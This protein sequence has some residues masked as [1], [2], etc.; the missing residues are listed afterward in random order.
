[1]Q[2]N[3]QREHTVS[4]VL[5]QRVRNIQT[6]IEVLVYNYS[7]LGK[8]RPTAHRSHITIPEPCEPTLVQTILHAHLDNPLTTPLTD[9][10]TLATTKQPL[11]CEYDRLTLYA[12]TNI[13]RGIIIGRALFCRVYKI[14]I[15]RQDISAILSVLLNYAHAYAYIC[16]DRHISRIRKLISSQQPLS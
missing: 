2:A 13:H 11:P 8:L 7:R 10:P 14:L 6:I 5:L 4:I 16:L 3:Q 12:S 9:K 1:M 15:M